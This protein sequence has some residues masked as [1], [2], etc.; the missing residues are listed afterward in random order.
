MTYRPYPDRDRAL[1]QLDRHVIPPE[2]R[3]PTE[4]ELRTAQQVN[5]VLTAMSASL[6]PVREALTQAGAPPSAPSPRG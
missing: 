2:P 6:R 1:R 5:A 3:Q 4:F